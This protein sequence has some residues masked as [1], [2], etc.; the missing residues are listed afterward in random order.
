V[1]ASDTRAIPLKV[2]QSAAA[3][4]KRGGREK[5][6]MKGTVLFRVRAPIDH[7]DVAVSVIAKSR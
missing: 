4:K 7:V 1:A 6:E 3:G 2:S 5:K